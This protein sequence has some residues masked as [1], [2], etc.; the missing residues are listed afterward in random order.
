MNNRNKEIKVR[1]TQE[2]YEQLLERKTKARLAE[3]VREY[4]LGSEP[5]R[6]TKSV[7]KVDPAL[8]KE[9]SKVGGNINQIA[10]HLNNDRSMG[11]EKKIEYLTELASIEQSLAE[12]LELFLDHYPS[13]TQES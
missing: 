11:L 1:L 8:L 9:L 7:L 3:W 2:E 10:R 5:S 12:L 6:K 13:K 4:C